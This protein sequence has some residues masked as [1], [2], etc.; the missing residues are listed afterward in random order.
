[1]EKKIVAWE[2][3]SFEM[4]PID[5]IALVDD[6]AIEVGWVALAKEKKKKF[7]TIKGGACRFHYVRCNG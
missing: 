7:Q 3:D 1:M 2:L 5:T 6:P 4:D